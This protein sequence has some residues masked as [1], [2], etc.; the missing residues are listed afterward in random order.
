LFFLRKATGNSKI[1][2]TAGATPAKAKNTAAATTIWRKNKFLHNQVELSGDEVMIS[3]KELIYETLA[4]RPVPRVPYMIEFTI[5][6][7]QKLLSCPDGRELYSRLDNDIIASKVIK[8]EYGVR[9]EK[10]L[11]T[12]EFGVVWDRSIDP[13]IGVPKSTSTLESLLQYPMPD[14]ANENRYEQLEQ[15]LKNHPEKFHIMAFDFAL[16]ER[17]WSLRGM[18]NLFIDLIDRPDLVEALLDKILCFNLAVMEIGLEKYPKVDGVYFGDDFAAQTGLQMGAKLWTAIIKPKLK[19]QY[20]FAR[21][22]GKKVFIHSCGKVQEL[23]DDFIE[24]GV[25]CFNP[26]QPEVMDVQRC[27]DEYHGRLAFH[28]GISTQKL[29]PYATVIEVEAQV[30]K[31]LKKGRD[32]G[33]IISP[34]HATPADA[35]TQNICAMLRKI[36]GQPTNH[37]L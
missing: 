16:Y 5:P 29:L 15:N 31:L 4:F 8:I 24:L 28:G 10:G 34:A 1:Y 30:D 13:D 18:Q 35:K 7:M 6:A 2:C 11:Y 3:S 33:Y 25:D 21:Q 12:D 17:A 22:A 37:S 36:L 9:N 20:G 14:P 26:F 27:L 23:F 19:K 32:G